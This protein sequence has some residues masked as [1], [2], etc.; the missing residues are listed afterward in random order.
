M[1]VKAPKYVKVLA[2][3]GIALTACPKGADYA[4]VHK[5]SSSEGIRWAHNTACKTVQALVSLIPDDK[6]Q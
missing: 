4:W 1:K 6:S 2:Q 3:R 5:L